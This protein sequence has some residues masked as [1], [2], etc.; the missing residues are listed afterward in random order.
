MSSTTIPTIE[1]EASE[2]TVGV[3]EMG[4]NPIPGVDCIVPGGT[5]K[6]VS[7]LSGSFE[8]PEGYTVPDSLKPKPDSLVWLA[9]FLVQSDDDLGSVLLP[10]EFSTRTYI[11]K[12][13]VAHLQKELPFVLDM[14][15]AT[16]IK[17]DSWADLKGDGADWPLV[18]VFAVRN[19]DPNVYDEFV[20][21]E[22]PILC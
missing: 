19:S 2:F 18:I 9:A 7:K 10:A 5:C 6:L 3:P 17:P 21:V 4:D 8:G 15:S 12:N 20:N 22:I 1:F 13:G 16:Y 14:E 11:D